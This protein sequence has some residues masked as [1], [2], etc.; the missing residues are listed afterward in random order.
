ARRLALDEGAR[1]RRH[2]ITAVPLSLTDL[3]AA[4]AAAEALHAEAAEG[5]GDAQ[6]E[7]AAA[8]R[9]EPLR[10]P[11]ADPHAR[12][13]PPPVRA[14]LK[15]FDEEQKRRS[16]RRQHDTIDTALTDLA[17]VYRDA[18]VL[19]TGAAVEPVN[20]PEAQTTRSLA[21]AMTPEELL[22]ALET[23]ALARQRL[24]A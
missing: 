8:A 18:L 3:G 2:R 11:G 16:R 21:A 7:E 22:G 19:G 13:Q 5:A 1:N 9:A 10:Q 24:V 15:A 20:A 17:S 6:G 4:L 23:I 12:A 14:H